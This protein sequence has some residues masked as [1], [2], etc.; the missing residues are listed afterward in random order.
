MALLLFMV[1]MLFESL[2]L[3]IGGVTY[4]RD[5]SEWGQRTASIVMP[6]VLTKGTRILVPFYNVVISSNKQFSGK[7]YHTVSALV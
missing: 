6:T 3:S 1:T 7:G 2:A 4:E 5:V